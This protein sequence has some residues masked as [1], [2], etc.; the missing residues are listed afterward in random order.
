LELSIDLIA[1]GSAATA[2]WVA[3]FED[4]DSSLVNAHGEGYRT[5][6]VIEAECNVIETNGLQRA[7][8]RQPPKPLVELALHKRGTWRE[9]EPLGEHAIP[10]TSIADKFEPGNC[11]G[12]A[13]RRLAF[14]RVLV[15]S[16]RRPAPRGPFDR[17][18]WIA[19]AALY[20]P[21]DT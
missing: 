5:V 2:S 20:W 18:S 13:G 14:E 17:W 10:N 21:A 3:P 11:V 8:L 16:V 1:A 4:A 6:E 12:L 15:G 7:K 9:S 19:S